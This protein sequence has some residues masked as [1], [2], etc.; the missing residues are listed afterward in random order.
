MT[1]HGI[2]GVLSVAMIYDQAKFVILWSRDCMNRWRIHSREQMRTKGKGKSG[3]S[4]LLENL[5]SE[6]VTLALS[7]RF[8]DRIVAGCRVALWDF[9]KRPESIAEAENNRIHK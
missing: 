6:K 7:F 8:S 4:F 2:K 3:G 5:S 9:S 1:D